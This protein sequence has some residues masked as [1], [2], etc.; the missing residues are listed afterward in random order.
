MANHGFGDRDGE[1]DLLVVI[2]VCAEGVVESALC[3]ASLLIDEFTADVV[4]V[5]EVADGLCAGEGIEVPG[6]QRPLAKAAVE[7]FLEKALE[8]GV[9]K[10]A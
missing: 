9:V 4:F 10:G 2:G 8:P 5:G 1:Q 3:L 6:Q 7:V